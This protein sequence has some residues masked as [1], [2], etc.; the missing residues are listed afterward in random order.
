M[1]DVG[2]REASCRR[3]S[4]LRQFPPRSQA[5]VR[6]FD[7]AGKDVRDALRIAE[8]FS[9][10]ADSL[11][12]PLPRYQWEGLAHIDVSARSEYTDEHR[13]QGKKS[14]RDPHRREH[15]GT[16]GELM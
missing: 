4:S 16:L 10:F 14:H 15:N 3:R 1:R 6:I 13:K 7:G 8:H 2:S 11:D 12:L 9:C 5:K